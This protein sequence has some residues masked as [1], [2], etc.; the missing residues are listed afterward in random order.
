MGAAT[1]TVSPADRLRVGP[2]AATGRVGRARTGIRGLELDRLSKRFGDIV[3]LDGLSLEARRGR[4]L[5]FLGP[6]GAGKTT[7][8][9]CIFGLVV[10]DIG[11]VRWQGRAVGPE[12]RRRFGY[13]PEERGLYPQMRVREQL[14]YLARL[15]GLDGRE[16][17][18]SVARWLERLG[19]AE[20]AE[21]Q[22]AA[23]SHG[24]QQRVQL[25]AALVHDP[26]LLVLDEPFAGL[27]PLG[28]EALAA[29]IAELAEAGAAVV[30]SSHQLDL[31]QDVCED[32]VV[33]EHGR[34]VLAGPLETLRAA[35][36]RRYV[37]VVFRDGVTWAPEL[38]T[39]RVLVA[40]PGRTRLELDASVD[41]ERLVTL[42][43]RAGE[44]TRF[45]FE[46]P[47]LSDL[48]REAVER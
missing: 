44:L 23:L 36:R 31:V 20:R 45:S 26:D 38:D 2:R 41:P 3:A 27:D 8:M 9:R 14:D 42:A 15:S 18:A 19:L 10:P 11:A 28:V 4:V 16:A 47:A 37:E 7:A 46:P 40:D 21:E 13:M 34:T 30:F 6:N 22:V 24:N 1:D 25:A 43:R 12:D 35:S 39:G 5:G 29:V 48:F 33:I 17:A 32:V